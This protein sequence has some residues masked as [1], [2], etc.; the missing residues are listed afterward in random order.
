MKQVLLMFMISML[1]VS[2][3][4]A[5]VGQEGHGGD[6]V[7][8]EF[9]GLAEEILESFKEL[10]SKDLPSEDFVALF[11][12]SLEK[13]EVTS[14]DRV[15]LGDTEVDAINFPD[16]D[17]PKIL[18]GRERWLDPRITMDMRKQLI[19]HEFLSIMGFDD[20]YYRLSHRLKQLISKP[21]IRPN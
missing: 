3:S 10:P 18:L 19:I 8:S 5:R 15:K 20:K 9:F 4:L 11:S 2:S 14:L 21:S 16:I 1:W 6:I 13:V 12:E 7:V 17:E